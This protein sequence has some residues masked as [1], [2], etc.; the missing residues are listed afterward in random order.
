M[1]NEIKHK[2]AN[3]LRKCE[4]EPD[5]FIWIDN[6]DYMWPEKVCGI[7]ILYVGSSVSYLPYGNSDLP[8]IPVW[9]NREQICFRDFEKGYDE[10]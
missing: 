2:I 9:R 4:F 10:Y 3:G 8:L 5:Y 1:N 7:S 6:Q